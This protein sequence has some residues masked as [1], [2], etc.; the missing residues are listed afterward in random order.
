MFE[1]ICALL[2]RCYPAGFRRAYGRDAAQLIRD[3][4]QHERGFVKRVRLLTDL[5]GDLFALSL[6]GWEPGPVLARTDSGPRFDIIEPHHTRPEAIAMGMVVTML[7]LAVCAV[8]AGARSYVAIAEWAHDL[9]LGV[10]VRLGLAGGRVTPSES[11]MR[12]IL[13]RA[14][15]MAGGGASLSESVRASPCPSTR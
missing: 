2:L 11:A 1:A 13:Q 12:R 7:A 5:T 14:P 3:R 6:R 15:A 10:R 8:L 9:P 4:A